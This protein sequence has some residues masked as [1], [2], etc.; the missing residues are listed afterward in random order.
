MPIV[1][2]VITVIS[3]SVWNFAGFGAVT[4]RLKT[5]ASLP[6]SRKGCSQA[7][8]GKLSF[9]KVA[10]LGSLSSYTT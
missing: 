8:C 1:I 2:R 7:S 4:P 5:K 6:E 10:L 3:H 9:F